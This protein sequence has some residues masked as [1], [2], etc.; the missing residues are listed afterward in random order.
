MFHKQ[1]ISWNTCFCHE[2]KK[3]NQTKPVL[4]VVKRR[5]ALDSVFWALVKVQLSE[6]SPSSQKTAQLTVFHVWRGMRIQWPPS[7]SSLTDVLL[8]AGL[9]GCKMQKNTLHFHRLWF[10]T[11]L[12]LISW[13]N[14]ALKHS[15][16]LTQPVDMS[17]LKWNGR[18]DTASKVWCF[19]ALGNNRYLQTDWGN[20][21]ANMIIRTRIIYNALVVK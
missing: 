12:L 21:T 15:R 13:E 19:D 7:S 1:E 8:Q 6:C 20:L 3:Q 4:E 17:Q 9:R 11:P 18:T 10:P 2:K 16:T 5:H 14:V